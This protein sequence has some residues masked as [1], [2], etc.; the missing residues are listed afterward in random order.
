MVFCI[1]NLNA[2][3]GIDPFANL[4]LSMLATE[5]SPAL[6]L[7]S[8]IVS[9]GLLTSAMVLAQALPKT[10]KSSKEFAPKRLAPCTDAQAVSPAAYRPKIEKKNV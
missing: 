1:A 5:A 9:P 8:A 3:V 6:A 2:A 4:N 7:K 10:T